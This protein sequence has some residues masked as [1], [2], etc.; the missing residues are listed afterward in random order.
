MSMKLSRRND[1]VRSGVVSFGRSSGC[2]ELLTTSHRAAETEHLPLFSASRV[3]NVRAT[4]LGPTAVG[5][6]ISEYY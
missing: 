2:L 5:K 4:S 3:A 6:S 1:E